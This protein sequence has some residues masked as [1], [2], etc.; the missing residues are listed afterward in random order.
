[1]TFYLVV[2]DVDG[3]GDGGAETYISRY[4]VVHSL[5]DAVSAVNNEVD[6]RDKMG[7]IALNESLEVVHRRG[8]TDSTQAV[9]FIQKR[10]KA[11]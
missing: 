9:E 7:A 4:N 2:W 5:A 10:L 11:T 8:L 6:N 3:D 1:M